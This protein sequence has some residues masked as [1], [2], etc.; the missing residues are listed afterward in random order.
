MSGSV[1][2]RVVADEVELGL[3]ALAEQHLVR[4]RDRHLA[5]GQ[6]EHVRVVAGHVRTVPAWLVGARPGRQDARMAELELTRSRDERRLYEVEGVG[7]LRFGGRL[8]RRAAAEAG[9][10]A[11]SFDHRGFWRTRIEASDATGAV[12][13]SFD[14]RK[15]RRGGSLRWDDRDFELR[16]ASRWNERYALADHDRELA[17]L[18][19]KGWGRRPVRITVDELSRV[20]PGLLLFAAFAVHHLAGR[21]L[22]RRRCLGRRGDRIGRR[23]EAGSVRWRIAPHQSA[24]QTPPPARTFARGGD[25]VLAGRVRCAAGSMR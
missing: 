21:Q 6:L 18:D 10:A 16:P 25:G 2:R 9:T 13:G 20:E 23:G 19:A 5:P 14:P 15:L 12:V 4:A 11:W 1:D 17:M 8:S 7:T 3:A 22:G 24:R